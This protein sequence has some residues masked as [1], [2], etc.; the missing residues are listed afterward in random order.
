MNI[1]GFLDNVCQEIKYKPVRQGIADEI[2]NHMQEIKEEYMQCGINETEAEQKA[3]EQM[4]EAKAIGKELN[5]LHRPKLDWK[6]LLITGILISFGFLVD[7]IR[8][9]NSLGDNVISRE[10]TKYIF[11]LG[12]GI[13]PSIIIYFLDY[14]KLKKYSNVIYLIATLSI[15]FTRIF[16]R[17]IN[18]K[19]Y[20]GS[21]A[22]EV[23]ALPLYIIAFAGFINDFEKENK[24][25]SIML[26]FTSKEIN[27]NVNF[28]LIKIILISVFSLILLTLIPSIVSV[29]ILLLTY[30]TISTIKIIQLNK[31][32]AKRLITLWG[33]TVAFGILFVLIF[34]GG[35][36]TYR[37]HKINILF[38]PESD[39]QGGGWAA[40]NR[41]I[42]IQNAKM[43]GEAENKS[44][45]INLFDDGTDY[46]F[47][48][49]IAHYG[50]IVGM[51]IVFAVMLFSF[52]LIFDAIKIK[53]I[54]GKFI[55][56]GLSSMFILQSIF[57]ILMNLN[58][59]VESGFS[60]PFVSY[61]IGNLIINIICLSLILSVYRRKDINL[62][63]KKIEKECE[64]NIL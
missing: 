8:I 40:I 47:I 29:F 45:A 53:E 38:N 34:I 49:I 32:K 4:G 42:I 48:S 28:N 5:K 21:I 11:F 23:I 26:R 9:N 55:V 56:I 36:G 60:L 54:Y 3:V 27:V 50:W 7:M 43:F 1:K 6:L 22:P 51:S 24:L 33:T 17:N 20:L 52:K 46:A 41:K 31:N 10:I 14:K 12:L 19:L 44:S 18:G 61:G 64:Q 57:S 16:G 13:I 37:L 30:L 58:L 39:S 62:Y 59:W 35:S 63:E 2:E 15:C 25:K